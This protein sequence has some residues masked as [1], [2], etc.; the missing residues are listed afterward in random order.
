[1]SSNAP[2]CDTSGSTDE[3]IPIVLT[4]TSTVSLTVRYVA[5]LLPLT[6]SSATRRPNPASVTSPNCI[7][8]QRPKRITSVST[9][10]IGQLKNVLQKIEMIVTNS[11]ISHRIARLL[12]RFHA[13]P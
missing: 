12:I 3:T 7:A 9:T 11:D 13:N 1:M 8:P 2:N 10:A 6:R 5:A 4:S